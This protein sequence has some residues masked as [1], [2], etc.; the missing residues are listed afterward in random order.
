M[1]PQDGCVSQKCFTKQLVIA[2]TVQV[3]MV[4][5]VYYVIVYKKP[6]TSE[7]EFSNKGTLAKTSHSLYYHVYH[8]NIASYQYSVAN[9][10]I[11]YQLLATMRLVYSSLELL[12]FPKFQ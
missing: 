7:E 3:S 6:W 10:L 4:A 12:L 11:F 9:C 1:V 5:E 2:G 8:I